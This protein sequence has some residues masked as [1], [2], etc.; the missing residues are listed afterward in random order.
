MAL[1][2]LAVVPHASADNPK[3][4]TNDV[5]LAVAQAVNTYTFQVGAALK[6]RCYHRLRSAVMTAGL[7]SLPLI[8]KPCG[9]TERQAPLSLRC[10]E[11]AHTAL[12]CQRISLQ[13]L[14][15]FLFICNC[16]Y[17]KDHGLWC[18]L[19]DESEGV[20]W[21]GLDADTLPHLRPR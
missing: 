3:V 15:S 18:L 11:L 17:Q 5:A 10:T 21:E 14:L 12:R 4:N 7:F 1:V 6:C 16:L 19:A 9:Q 20:H 2:D 8:F 13:I